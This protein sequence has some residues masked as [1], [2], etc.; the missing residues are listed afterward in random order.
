MVGASGLDAKSMKW[1]QHGDEFENL[2]EAIF[3]MRDPMLGRVESCRA[4]GLTF[5]TKVV[6]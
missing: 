5:S 1:I 2:S 3:N 4:V 6:F